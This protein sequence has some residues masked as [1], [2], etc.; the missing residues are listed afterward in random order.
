MWRLFPFSCPREMLSLV[1]ISCY[2]YAQGFPINAAEVSKCHF[3]KVRGTSH[4]FP[5]QF[6]VGSNT[7]Q[8]PSPDFEIKLED[9]VNCV[10]RNGKREDLTQ[11]MWVTVRLW[12]SPRYWWKE[13]M[14][15][16]ASPAAL[17]GG[18]GEWNWAHSSF[19]LTLCLWI[20][21]PSLSRSRFNWTQ[22]TADLSF[23]DSFL[24]DCHHSFQ[25]SVGIWCRA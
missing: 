7:T 12:F 17:A 19:F 15:A 25:A 24:W 23:P 5:L 22:A 4:F 8:G 21:S 10:H 3:T 6:T 13:I 1:T 20:Q 14:T 16:V 11:T 2:G 9:A 18:V